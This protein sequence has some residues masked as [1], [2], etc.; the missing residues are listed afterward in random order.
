[1]CGVS[2]LISGTFES[3]NIRIFIK[4]K[5]LYQVEITEIKI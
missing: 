2:P 4:S 3:K 1:M 5:Y